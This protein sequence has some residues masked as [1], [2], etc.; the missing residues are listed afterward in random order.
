[1]EATIYIQEAIKAIEDLPNCYNGYSDIYDKAYIIEVLEELPSTEKDGRWIDDCFYSVCHW[2]VR[3]LEQ[4][5]I[6]RRNQEEKD[7]V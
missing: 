6:G 7:D 4:K 1:M 5:W 3:T 2:T